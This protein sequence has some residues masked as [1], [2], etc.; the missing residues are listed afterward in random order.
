MIPPIRTVLTLRFTWN[1]FEFFRLIIFEFNKLQY[2]QH[3][4]ASNFVNSGCG[5]LFPNLIEVGE[6][7]F[8]NFGNSG[9]SNQQRNRVPLQRDL[10]ALGIVKKELKTARIF[11]TGLLK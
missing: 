5:F 6:F 2:P 1:F 10:N 3:K 4:S 9:M 11:T 8:Q 7:F